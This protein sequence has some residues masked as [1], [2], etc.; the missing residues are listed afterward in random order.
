MI[1]TF[2]SFK[3]GVGRSMSMATIAYLFAQRGLKVLVIDFDLEAPGLERYFFDDPGQL[4]E[5]RSNP[6]LIDLVLAYKRALTSETEFQRAEFKNWRTFI[7][8]AIPRTPASGAVDL[9]TSGRRYPESR[10]SEYALVV[11]GFDWQD[12]FHNWRGDRFFEWLR[13]E[14]TN[15]TLGYDAVLVDSRT[16]VTEMGG[17]CAYQLADV[18]VLMCAP[19]YQNLDGTHAVVADFRSDA[20]KALRGGRPLELLVVPARVEQSDPVKRERFFEDLERIFGTDGLPIVLADAGLNYRNLAMPYRPELAIIERLVDETGGGGALSAQSEARASFERLTDALTLMSDGERWAPLKRAARKR[21]A[22]QSLEVEAGPVADVTQRAAGY[23]AFVEYHAEDSPQGR[24]LAQALKARGLAVWWDL[25]LRVSDEWRSAVDRA[26]EYSHALIVCIGSAGPSEWSWRALQYSQARRKRIVPVLLPDND[27]PQEMLQRYGLSHL[28][29]VDL[30]GGIS[31]SVIQPLV[32]VLAREQA[33]VGATSREVPTPYP[34]EQPYTEELGPVFAGRDGEIE[35]LL[36]EF[37]EHDV[38]LLEGPAGIG[39]T[40]IVQAGLLP[41]VRRAEGPFALADGDTAWT[42]R[43]VA[44]DSASRDDLEHMVVAEDNPP[45][46][47]VL[48]GVDSFPLGGNEET[49]RHRIACIARALTRGS[50]RIRFLLVW[51]GSLPDA[52]RVD[53]LTALQGN[54]AIPVQGLTL[55]PLSP[56]VLRTVVEKTAAFAGHLLE[57]GLTDR[58]LRDAGTQS[59]AVSQI[60]IALADIWAKRTRGWLTN[61]AYDAAAGIAGHFGKRLERCLLDSREKVGRAPEVL[62]TNLLQFDAQFAVLP[63]AHEWTTLASIPAIGGT[64]G[65]AIRDLL[66]RERLIDM[67]RDEQGHLICALAQPTPGPALEKLARADATFILWRQR[68]ASYVHSFT[69]SGRVA[70]ALLSGDALREADL[71]LSSH[72]D[73]LSADERALIESSLSARDAQEVAEADRQRLQNERLAAERDRAEHERRRAEAARRRAVKVARRFKIAAVVTFAMSAVAVS[74]LVLANVQRREIA[75]QAAEIAVQAAVLGARRLAASDPTAGAVGLAGALSNDGPSEPVLRAM[76]FL[77]HEPLTGARMTH[78]DAITHAAFL[79]ERRGLVTAAADAVR[80]WTFDGH[81]QAEVPGP[82]SSVVAMAVGNQPARV[83]V[84]WANGDLRTIDMNGQVAEPAKIGSAIAFGASFSNDGE[85]LATASEN[86]GSVRIWDRRGRLRTTLAP[87]SGEPGVVTKIT[88]SPTGDQLLTIAA[89]SVRVWD[90]DG[91]QS[92]SFV[93][94]AN[95]TDATFSGDGRYVVI[96]DADGLASVRDIGSGKPLRSGSVRSLRGHRGPVRRAVFS[97]DGYYIATTSDDGTAFVSDIQGKIAELKGHEK[98]VTDVEFFGSGQQL[99]ILTISDDQ[100][101]RIWD[102]TGATLARLQGHGGKVLVGHFDR[103]GDWVLTASSDRTARLWGL[104]RRLTAEL[105]TPSEIIDIGLSADGQRAVTATTDGRSVV[106]TIE[107]EDVL[108]LQEHDESVVHATFSPDGQRVATA[109]YDGTVRISTLRDMA[110]VK[111]VGH[112]ESVQHVAFSPNGRHLLTGSLD[113]SARLWDAQGRRVATLDGHSG[114]VNHVAFSPRGERALTASADHTARL[115]SI[116][117]T[118]LEGEGG[119]PSIRLAHVLAGHKGAVQVAV[120][121]P[122]GNRILTGSAD[123]TARLWEINGRPIIALSGHK[124]AVVDVAFNRDGTRIATASDDGTVHL[125]NAQG[126]T[127]AV[128]RDENDTSRALRTEFS[129]GGLIATAFQSGTVRVWSPDGQLLATLS[130]HERP[131]TRASFTPGGEYL[132]TA[133]RDG[134][135]RAWPLMLSSFRARL[136]RVAMPCLLQSEL[137]DYFLVDARTA[138]DRA[139][140]CTLASGL[141]LQR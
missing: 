129:R 59:G 95:V 102:E 109:S 66:L 4:A 39:K 81:L 22:G 111:L 120:F 38:V 137:Q 20:V 107:N 114:A 11:R 130:G 61:K 77:P 23:D 88:F 135:V 69:Q 141:E 64:D 119:A 1:F 65:L 37:Y 5:I 60:Q 123:S 40:S 139:R 27:N 106:W 126:Q 117:D 44:L 18:A 67:W 122:D 134:T 132:V 118:R 116:D 62:L 75:G 71:W 14:L 131:V 103:D 28:H 85:L 57:P 73:Q 86:D 15:D 3:G 29:A 83:V 41:R 19:N 47:W 31:E 46:L 72:A 35:A 30:R 92:L 6:G 9:M 80:F 26:L 36:R 87:K 32:D 58:L 52:E 115:W 136:S 17:V 24:V 133:S 94:G 96:G 8:D 84:A 13:A 45:A 48:D 56:A 49:R 50:G 82:D 140:S 108:S 51:R 100:T 112:S 101:A 74:L 34:G 105:R 113:R 127:L 42:V 10:Y 21:L 53:A 104:R 54:S 79:P 16:G 43:T 55:P 76:S 90:I 91:G 7:V 138:A 98:P 63:A 12:F 68:F 124:D 110:S 97:R 25:D 125:W 78:R 93:A 2:Y 121:S 128:L 33:P 89:N 70:T 99:K